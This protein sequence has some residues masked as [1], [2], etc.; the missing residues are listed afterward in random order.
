MIEYLAPSSGGGALSYQLRQITL[1]L[2]G[3][4]F[5]KLNTTPI[6]LINTNNS[7]YIC[8]VNQF[9]QYVNSNI[10]GTTF[11]QV[12]FES[13][14]GAA[15]NNCTFSLFGPNIQGARGMLSYINLTFGGP[16]NSLHNSP[17]VLWS[18]A[19]DLFCTFDKFIITINYFLIPKV[20]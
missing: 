20:I 11:I 19:D 4:D 1:D 10:S 9:C 17:L 6:T 18:S 2:T 8:V 15:P 3:S 16:E 12:G 5:T 7:D 14:M 13:L